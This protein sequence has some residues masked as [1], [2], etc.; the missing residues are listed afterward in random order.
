ME[1]SQWE[2]LRILAS[3]GLHTQLHQELKRLSKDESFESQLSAVSAA[4]Q[5][6]ALHGAAKNGHVECVK[7]LIEFKASPH[8]IN[9][10]GYTPILEAQVKASQSPKEP[11]RYHTIID[12]LARASR[13]SQQISFESLVERSTA[14]PINMPTMAN[15]LESVCK[16]VAQTR[17]CPL[18]NVKKM[19][20]VQ[21]STVWPIAH[22]R[23]VQLMDQFV[24]WKSSHGTPVEKALYS[25]M[26][27][28]P[29]L[30]SNGLATR[31]LTRRP[32]VFYTPKDVCILPSQLPK[33]KA[34][35]VHELQPFDP[36][37]TTNTHG[38][39]G[40]DIVGSQEEIDPLQLKDLLSYDEMQLSALFGVSSS[41]FFINNGE[42]DNCGLCAGV[43]EQEGIYV[44]VV[45]ARFERK[46]RMEWEHMLI[47]RDQNTVANGYGAAAEQ[48]QTT[49]LQLWAEFYE[50]GDGKK[51]LLPIIRGGAG[52][53]QGGR[54]G[55]GGRD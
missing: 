49:L 8:V 45:G 41:T 6:A 42:R 1:T 9:H 38:D 34:T 48:S 26:G 2:K 35:S 13:P 14:M 17:K 12:M 40:F 18:E 32:I 47:T 22:G 11:R 46:Q 19:I 55:G 36:S 52:R 25:S 3:N 16:R 33:N 10:S 51:I 4:T 37:G 28:T 15:R 29:T 54:E 27:D 7:I 43:F 50:Q 24:L 21:A 53:V 5:T 31:L 23:L 20:G 30:R 39:K 44:G